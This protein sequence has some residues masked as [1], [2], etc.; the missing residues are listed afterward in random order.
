MLP[1]WD[2]EL[3]ITNLKLE[4]DFISEIHEYISKDDKDDKFIDVGLGITLER[5]KKILYYHENPHI[6]RA[7]REICASLPDIDPKTKSINIIDFQTPTFLTR[8]GRTRVGRFIRKYIDQKKEATA[9][10][11]AAEPAEAEEAEGDEEAEEAEGD[12]EAEEEEAEG[13]EEAEEEEEEEEPAAELEKVSEEEAF[14][15]ISRSMTLGPISILYG[16]VIEKYLDTNP[17]N[18]RNLAQLYNYLINIYIKSNCN[19]I[20]GFVF[21]EKKQDVCYT[22]MAFLRRLKKYLREKQLYKKA[23]KYIN[24]QGVHTHYGG[25]NTNK[26]RRLTKNRRTNKKRPLTKRR[27]TKKRKSTKRRAG[28]SSRAR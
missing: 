14:G 27:P 15:K 21:N 2:W 1:G 7:F 12:K 22:I 26:K 3:F 13:D 6:I 4:K 8:V 25:K 10:E 23:S 5:I 18:I 28:K 20:F 19:N 9:A 16:G 11:P 24:K 17:I